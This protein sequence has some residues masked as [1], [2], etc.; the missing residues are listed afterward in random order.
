MHPVKIQP[1]TTQATLGGEA[2]NF[3]A[4]NTAG[5]TKSK[6]SCKVSKGRKEIGLGPRTVSLKFSTGEGT[7]PDG[8][9]PG[10]IL[11]IPVFKK[12]LW[13]SVSKGDTANYLS[14]A[15]VVTS[16]SP[17]SKV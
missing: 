9:K 16:T 8:Y 12:S 5:V 11:T 2:N 3:P 7:F 15:C 10:T 4:S 6:I 13:D 1:E 17:E 14:K